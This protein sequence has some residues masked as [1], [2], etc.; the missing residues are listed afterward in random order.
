MTK[1]LIFLSACLFSTFLSTGFVEAFALVFYSV[2]SALKVL[3]LMR[4]SPFFGFCP[5]RGDG[6]GVW[7]GDEAVPQCMPSAAGA[8]CVSVG[9]AANATS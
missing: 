7:G 5:R 8:A 1:A 2:L 6:V 4:P 3:R 9:G